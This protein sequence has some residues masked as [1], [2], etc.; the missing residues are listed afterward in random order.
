MT[1]TVDWDVK[2]QPNK[3][4][5]TLINEWLETFTV[6]YCINGFQYNRAGSLIAKF[7]D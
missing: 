3:Q 1:I 7:I 2:P 5:K 4:T 6:S